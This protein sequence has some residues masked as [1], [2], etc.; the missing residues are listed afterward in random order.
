MLETQLSRRPFDDA[1]HARIAARE[2][3]VRLVCHVPGSLQEVHMRLIDADVMGIQWIGVPHL[4][5]HDAGPEVAERLLTMDTHD[6]RHAVARRGDER[7]GR[8]GD[9]RAVRL[10]P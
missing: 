3:L 10:S 2:L 6:S 1:E 7:I 9:R 4:L 8:R 5:F